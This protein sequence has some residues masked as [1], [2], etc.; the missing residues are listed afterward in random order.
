[1]TKLVA[2]KTE[3]ELSAALQQA[4]A[5]GQPHS[6]LIF[7]DGA[8]K[9]ARVGRALFKMEPYGSC[10][11]FRELEHEEVEKHRVRVEHP[12]FPTLTRYF[13]DN[14]AADAFAEPFRSIDG[15]TLDQNLVTVRVDGAGKVIAELADN[16]EVKPRDNS[17]DI[18]F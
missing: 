3:A 10:G 13:D 2:I 6:D 8:V 4:P 18:P 7:V 11:V 17:D 15:A 1:M 12:N 16:G 9:G 14:R 5:E